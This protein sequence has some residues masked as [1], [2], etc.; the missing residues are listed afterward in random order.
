MAAHGVVASLFALS[1]A[2]VFAAFPIAYAYRYFVVDRDR[3]FIE[4]AF[5]RYVDPEV[6]EAIAANPKKLNLGGEKRHVAVFFSDIAGFT[7]ISENI[8][9][10]KLFALIGEYLSQM[11]DIL[12]Q[13]RGTL[14]KYVG[15]AVMGIF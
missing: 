5:S 11:T 7:T 4:K 8:G 13:N 9:T 1:I 2:G 15:D 6:V 10:D 14:D 3:H 12:I